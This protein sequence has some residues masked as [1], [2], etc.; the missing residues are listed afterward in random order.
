MIQAY[1]TP[2][3]ISDLLLSMCSQ[4][5]NP[6]TMKD[7]IVLPPITI[8]KSDRGSIKLCALKMICIV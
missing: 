8:R 5:T 2:K 3:H 1:E 7:S 4:I 6:G